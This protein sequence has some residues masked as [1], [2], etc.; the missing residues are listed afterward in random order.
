MQGAAAWLH[1]H[2]QASTALNASLQCMCYMACSTHSDACVCAAPSPPPLL[3]VLLLRSAQPSTPR[4]LARGGRGIPSG[5]HPGQRPAVLCVPHPRGW[6]LWRLPRLLRRAQAAADDAAA[7]ADAAVASGAGSCRSRSRDS[8][9]LCPLVPTQQLLQGVAD[10]TAVGARGKTRPVLRATSSNTLQVL[11]CSSV[12]SV[13]CRMVSSGQHHVHALLAKPLACR[14]HVVFYRV[15]WTGRR[16]ALQPCHLCVCM[17]SKAGCSAHW[18]DKRGPRCP[19][20]RLW[21]V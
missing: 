12:S 6:G 5:L 1:G 3:P 2:L 11:R 9:M 20:W 16:C 15:P 13:W 17:L 21:S 19:W 7:A 8:R 14:Q 10:S 4:R 18:Q